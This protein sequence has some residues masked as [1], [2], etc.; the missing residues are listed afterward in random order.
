MSCFYAGQ[1][2]KA[3][4][5]RTNGLP[6][7]MEPRHAGSAVVYKYQYLGSRVVDEA[8]TYYKVWDQVGSSALLI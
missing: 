8:D 7:N 6:G 1:E 3:K 5:Q 4:I 2:Q